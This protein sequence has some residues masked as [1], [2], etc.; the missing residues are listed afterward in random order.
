[1]GRRPA[2]HPPLRARAVEPPR[3]PPEARDPSRVWIANTATELRHQGFAVDDD[4]SGLRDGEAVLRASRD[5]VSWE[6]RLVDARV[7]PPATEVG[8]RAAGVPVELAVRPELLGEGLDKLLGTTVDERVG[9]EGF[10]ATF[11]VAAAPPGIAAT[12]LGPDVR[13]ALV[14]MPRTDDGPSLALSDGRI[15]L[16]WRAHPGVADLRRALGIVTSLR[17]VHAGLVEGVSYG[18]GPF[19]AV[20]AGELTVDPSARASAWRRIARA[21]RRTVVLAGAVAAA[22]GSF[23]AAALLHHR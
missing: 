2:K 8:C 20:G 6:V 10:D 13:D 9:D 3:N 12:L 4:P 5:G 17:V 23:V 7:G 16:R 22:V 18:A 1:M 14:M 19:R 15:T 11:V 21:R